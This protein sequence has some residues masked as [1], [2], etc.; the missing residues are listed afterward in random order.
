VTD[1]DHGSTLHGV[2]GLTLCRQK[3]NRTRKRGS[4]ACVATN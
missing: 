1:L 3:W 4:C 2:W